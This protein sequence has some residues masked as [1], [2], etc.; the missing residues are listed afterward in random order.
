MIFLIIML[1]SFSILGNV[2]EHDARP[3]HL[4]DDPVVA[5]SDLHILRPTELHT[6]LLVDDTWQVDHMLYILLLYP[7]DGFI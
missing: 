4:L 1:F 5:D 7:K 3:P 6:R 2:V